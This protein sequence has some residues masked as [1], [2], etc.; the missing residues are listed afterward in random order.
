MDA[1]PL[2]VDT[3]NDVNAVLGDDAA[4]PG[5]VDAACRVSH[6]RRGRAQRGAAG[7]VAAED[8]AATALTTVVRDAAASRVRRS[9]AL[10]PRSARLWRH[11]Q[12]AGAGSS[13]RL[14]APVGS[15]WTAIVSAWT[16]PS[17]LSMCTSSP[18][19]SMN[20]LPALYVCPAQLSAVWLVTVPATTRIRLGPGW[21]CQPVVPPGAVVDFGA[22][23]LS[24]TYTSD[25]PRVWSRACQVSAGTVCALTLNSS[26]SDLARIV[27][28]RPELGVAS[29]L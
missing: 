2:Q 15:S 3:C 8:A 26:K 5:G 17:L 21:E 4:R 18:P 19:A 16:L 14:G 7:A 12:L 29:T 13:I 10:P 24:T 9:D 23:L 1:T 27:V 25:C 20:P 22:S 11:W 6:R 28:V